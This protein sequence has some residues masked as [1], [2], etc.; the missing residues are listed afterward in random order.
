MTWDR[1]CRAKEG[2]AGQAC[3]TTEGEAGRSGSGVRGPGQVVV[4]AE[5]LMAPQGALPHRFRA[6]LPLLHG[7]RQEEIHRSIMSPPHRG[8]ESGSDRN[9]FQNLGDPLGGQ[10]LAG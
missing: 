2:S 9:I 5:L 10:E 4:V 6:G 8:F 7:N 3:S 1:L